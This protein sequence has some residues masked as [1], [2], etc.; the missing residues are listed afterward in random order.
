MYTNSE[1]VERI[2]KLARERKTS[3]TKIETEL[4]FGNGMIGKWAKAPKSP[5]YDKL[6]KIAEYLEV[7]VES[8]VEEERPTTLDNDEAEPSGSFYDRYAEL[9]RS[10]GETPNSVAKSL[11]IPSGSITA[12][13]NGSQPRNNTLAKIADYFNVSTDYLLRQEKTSAPLSDAEVRM[14]KIKEI[15]AL[16]NKM[17]DETIIDVIKYAEYLASREGK[18]DEK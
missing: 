9:C 6:L 13:K 4:N 7:S 18:S 11:G 17:D 8:L 2:R 15:E 1:I 5:P 16:L 10:S 3:L 12:W 14:E